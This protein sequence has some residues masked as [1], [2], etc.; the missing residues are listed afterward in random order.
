MDDK[1]QLSDYLIDHLKVQLELT[2]DEELS[3]PLNVILISSY[4]KPL[5]RDKDLLFLS[6][7]NKFYKFVCSPNIDPGFAYVNKSLFD[8]LN[9]KIINMYFVNYLHNSNEFTCY[10]KIHN[11][12][13]DINISDIYYIDENEIIKK[14]KGLYNGNFVNFC[15]SFVINVNDR[16][17][18]IVDLRLIISTKTVSGYIS[19]LTNINIITNDYNLSF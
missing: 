15:D 9:N 5:C 19:P 8:L 6:G 17:G 4:Y 16:Y 10:V 14:I 13:D 2:Y 18:K 12:S 11:K 7:F 3:S 1:M